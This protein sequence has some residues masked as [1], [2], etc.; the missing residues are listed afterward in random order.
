MSLHGVVLI[1]ILA[2]GYIVFI[3]DLIRRQRLAIGYALLWLAAVVCL[4]TLVNFTPL[5]DW[6][7]VM[8]GAT[9]PASALSLLAFGFMFVVLIY[10]SVQ[11][12]I[13]SA[14]QVELI[15]AITLLEL[16]LKERA[17]APQEPTGAG[18]PVPWPVEANELTSIPSG[19]QPGDGNVNRVG[20]APLS[21]T[22]V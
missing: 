15:Q 18:E 21:S 7:T 1:D 16:S 17:R 12:S 22:D 20:P 8:V 2:L 14:R 9:Y 6:I 19:F 11:L 10:F 3:L 5:R 13:M 4:M